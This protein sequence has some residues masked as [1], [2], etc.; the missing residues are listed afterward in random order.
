MDK[1]EALKHINDSA[2]ENRKQL[3]NRIHGLHKAIDNGNARYVM[4]NVNDF[5]SLLFDVIRYK[6]AQQHPEHFLTCYVTGDEYDN[7]PKAPY[8]HYMKVINGS[9]S[10]FVISNKLD[11]SSIHRHGYTDENRMDMFRKRLDVIEQ[12]LNDTG[13]D[14]IIWSVNNVCI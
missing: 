4:L 5:E 10:N 7:A 11:D 12:L 6:W 9:L 2:V 8:S 14:I 3:E 13:T 1:E